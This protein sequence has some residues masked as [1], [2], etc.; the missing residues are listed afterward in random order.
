MILSWHDWWLSQNA[1][2]YHSYWDPAHNPAHLVKSEIKDIYKAKDKIH[3]L[4][5]RM[6]NKIMKNFEDTTGV[7]PF[8]Q[9]KN[10]RDWN[11]RHSIEREVNSTAKK[12]L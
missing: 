8:D 12:V 9:D 10:R 7:D 2:N 5:N 3:A 1:E 11:N 6:N 4:D